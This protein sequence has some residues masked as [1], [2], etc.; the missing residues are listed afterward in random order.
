MVYGYSHVQFSPLD[1]SILPATDQ[2]LFTL[3]QDNSLAYSLETLLSHL[4]IFR[5]MG[6]IR[7]LLHLIILKISFFIDL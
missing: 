4:T 1:Y 7:Q 5:S 2:S 3:Q 6:G